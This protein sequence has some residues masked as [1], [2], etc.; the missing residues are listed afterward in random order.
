MV[1]RYLTF[2]FCVISFV[3]TSTSRATDLQI[4]HTNDLHGHFEHSG[5]DVEQGGYAYI[6]STLDRLKQEAQDQGIE[7]LIVDAGD[8]S[9]GSI[10]YLANQ[11]AN[12]FRMMDKMGYEAV[13]LGNHDWM[14]GVERLDEILGWARPRFAFLGANFKVN[15]RLR[16]HL[17]K[18]IQPSTVIIKSGVRIGILGLTTSDM[19]YAWRAR[20]QDVLRPLVNPIETASRL[21]PHLKLESDLVIALTH[22]GIE[23]DRKLVRW[24]EGIDLVIGGH[25][26]SLLQEIIRE[27]NL[28][29][30]SIPIVQ[31]GEHGSYVGELRIR[32]ENNSF[33]VLSYQLHP[34]VQE[35]LKPH[36][37]VENY[38]EESWLEV[39][40][41]YGS[42]FLNRIIGTL[43]EPIEVD[44]GKPSK[45]GKFVVETF[46][47]SAQADVAF[48]VPM[49]IGVRQKSGQ[50]SQDQLFRL[51]PRLF[52]FNQ[53]LGWNVWSSQTYGGILKTFIKTIVSLKLPFNLA[54]ITYDTHTFLGHTFA[55][56]IRINGKPIVSTATYTVALSE[57]IARGADEIHPLFH[58]ILRNP[59]DTGI[60]IWEALAEN[61][62]TFLDF[63]PAVETRSIRRLNAPTLLHF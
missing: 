17:K 59:S 47:K 1:F 12:A 46:R 15:P 41:T 25:S 42:K 34:I 57:G 50:I 23:K 53:T 62:D 61:F 30:Q 45:W 6:K 52:D 5:D 55:T 26:H 29:D 2:Y 54:G 35:E 11:G 10:F 20:D 3:L 28:L 32:F 44:R 9:E 48:D 56:N 19:T 13:T 31:A 33:E 60:P 18:F 38:I 21:L 8:F 58:A 24:T 36:S 49:F 37:L 39:I 43:P 4:L 40:A 27:K 22:L 63:K 7:T 16:P 51:Y 14:M